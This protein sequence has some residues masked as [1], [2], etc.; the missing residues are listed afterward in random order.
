MNYRVPGTEVPG[1]GGGREFHI[2]TPMSTSRSPW[3][4]QM[5]DTGSAIESR[6]VTNHVSRADP[7]LS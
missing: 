6:G 5:A 7:V 2:V 4:V 3:F 1:C